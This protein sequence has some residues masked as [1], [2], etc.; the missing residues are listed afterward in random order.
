LISLYPAMRNVPTNKVLR[1]VAAR[2]RHSA[3]GIFVT[4][5]H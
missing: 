2:E 5:L 3:T 4:A 1:Q